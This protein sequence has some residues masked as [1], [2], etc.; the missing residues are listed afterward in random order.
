MEKVIQQAHDLLNRRY[1]KPV[2][3]VEA[4]LQTKS[5]KLYESVN[6]DHFSGFVCAETSALANAINAGEIDFAMVA[7]VRREK[8]GTQTVANMCGKCR[9]IFHDYAPGIAIVVN[10]GDDNSVVPIEELLPY[11]F[12]RQKEKIQEAL[13]GISDDKVVG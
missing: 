12:Q 1:K 10:A 3:T 13:R 5:G 9:Q 2:H 8:D 6:I 7:A 11:S 4:V